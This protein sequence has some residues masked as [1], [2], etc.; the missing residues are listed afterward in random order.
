MH[1]SAAQEVLYALDDAHVMFPHGWAT[2]ASKAKY[3]GWQEL[4]AVGMVESQF[5]PVCTTAHV[6]W[7]YRFTADPFAELTHRFGDE[8]TPGAFKVWSVEVDPSW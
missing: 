2:T 3:R 1:S 8:W 6:R 4:D 7:M 5:N